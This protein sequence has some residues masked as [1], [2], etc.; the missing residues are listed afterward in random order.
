VIGAFITGVV[1]GLSCGLAPGPLLTLVLTQ[2]LKHGAREGFK[3]ALTPLITDIP[4]IL[5]AAILA[6]QLGTLRPVLGV[7]SIAG[8]VFVLYLAWESLRPQP[9]LGTA[10]GTIPNSWLRGVITNLL[11]PYPWLFWLTVGATTLAKGWEQGWSAAGAFLA[12]FYLLLVG[13]KMVL[14]WLAGQSRRILTARSYQFT[15]RS[16]GLLMIVFAVLLLREGVTY[17]RASA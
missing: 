10:E 6:A 14:A 12:S 3:I 2:S 4:M 16:L 13:S 11:S 7:V 17:L 9:E 5:A 15:L 8:G 1:L